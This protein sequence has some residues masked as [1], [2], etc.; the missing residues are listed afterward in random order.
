MAPLVLLSCESISK[1]YGVKPLFKDLS[2]ALFDGDHVG[3][4]GPNGSGKSTLLK[5]LAGIEEP[6]RGTRSMRRQLRVGY[7]PQDAVFPEDLTVEEVLAQTLAT[8]ELDPVEHHGRVA[9]ALSLGEFPEA[10]QP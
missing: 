7:V 4:V 9:R 2:L 3:V 6:D 8:E 10:D 1:T 5:I